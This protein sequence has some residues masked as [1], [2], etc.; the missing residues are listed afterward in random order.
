[1]FLR[2]NINIIILILINNKIEQNRSSL[3]DWKLRIKIATDVASGLVYLHTAFETPF[4]HRDIK[5]ANILLDNK[6]IAKACIYN[7]YILIM[8]NIMYLFTMF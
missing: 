6:F 8:L 1:M 2:N 7:L 3:L 4:I 5:S